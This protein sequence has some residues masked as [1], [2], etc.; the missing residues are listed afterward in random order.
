MAFISAPSKLGNVLNI[1]SEDFVKHV[2]SECCMNIQV[3]T[4]AICHNIFS[5]AVLC[6]LLKFV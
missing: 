1:V 3:G 6:E 5:I 2:I 4:K